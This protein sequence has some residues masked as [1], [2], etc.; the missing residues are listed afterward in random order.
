[1]AGAG[2][3]ARQAERPLRVGLLTAEPDR[4]LTNLAVLTGI[5]FFVLDAE[6]TGLDVSRCAD[7]VSRLTRTRTEVL[8]RI[9]DVSEATVVAF[10]NTG[11]DELVLPQVR[12]LAQI[13]GAWRASRYFPD[14]TRSRQVSQASAYGTDFVKVPRL[15]VLLETVE[16]IEQA[17]EFVASGLLDGAWIGPTDLLDDLRRFR[18]AEAERMS[19]LVDQAI[20]TFRAARV[21]IGLPA[22]DP[23]GVQ[24]AFAGGADRCAVYW[25]KQLFAVLTDVAGA[26]KG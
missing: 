19:E 22:K 9:P 6:L 2:A 24:E 15:S 13:E 10:A 20:A 25:E 17:A 16:A 14:G 8:I 26:R 12:T 5:D 7:V 3:S 1:M 21:S 23:A 4:L 11:A 18:P